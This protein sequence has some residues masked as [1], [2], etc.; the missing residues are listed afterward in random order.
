MTC[1]LGAHIRWLLPS[2]NAVHIRFCRHDPE[3]QP[4]CDCWWHCLQDPNEWTAVNG[5]PQLANLV[6]AVICAAALLIIASIHVSRVIR[7]H[8]M[9]RIW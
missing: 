5:E 3:L 8:I 4:V 1:K 7:C 6:I 2:G 9:G